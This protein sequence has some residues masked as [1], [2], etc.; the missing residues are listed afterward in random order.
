MGLLFGRGAREV[1]QAFPEP[2][3]P[4]FPG[5]NSDGTVSVGSS[6]DVAMTVPTV[7]A[8]V[9]LL[10]NAISMLPLKTVQQAKDGTQR[11]TADPQ[12]V[13]S[14]SADFTPSEWLHML[15]VSLLLRGNFYGHIVDR[16][17]LQKPTQIEPL[18]PDGIRVEIDRETGAIVYR[19]Q[20]GK[21]LPKADIWHVRGLTLAGTK[22]GLS[23]I[24]Y[25]AAQI[26]IDLNAT[27]FASDYFAGGGIPKAVLT[28]DQQVDQTQAQTIKERL[29]Q[30]TW[31]R[32][33]AVLGAGLKYTQVQ[34]KPE[35]SQFLATR[36]AT[37][38]QIARYFSVPA[39]MVGGPS[40]DSLTYSTVEQNSLNFLTYSVAFWLR[41]IEDAMAPLLP[42]NARVVFDTDALMRTDARSQAEV[43]VLQVAGKLRAPSEI[44]AVRGWAPLTQAQKDEL[45][46]TGLAVTPAGRVTSTGIPTQGQALPDDDKEG[47]PS[48]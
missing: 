45:D 36:Q 28:T 44:R 21:V 24:A 32:E 11:R 46:L 30:A 10:A 26:G 29:Q 31:N 23:P 48:A 25:A 13:R 47:A 39:N 17:Y 3:I 41:R 9:A 43:D 8:C 7:W 42:G 22:V 15:M 35:E 1:R 38:A 27:K 18:N 12:L 34:V 14:P 19:N 37:V 6:P 40:G 5:A 16:D 4:P 20:A 33:P 2:V